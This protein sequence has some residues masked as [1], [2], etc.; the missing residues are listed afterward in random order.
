MKKYKILLYIIAAVMIIT[1]AMIVNRCRKAE[2]N[3]NKTDEK[4]DIS[5][6]SIK[7]DDAEVDDSDYW[8]VGVPNIDIPPLIIWD[9]NGKLTGFE[10]DL[11]KETAKRL[12]LKYK[13]I[14]IYPGMERELLEDEIINVA[15]GNMMDTGKQRLFYDMT[16]PYITI[17]QVI[18]IYE[19]TG[20]ND[21]KDI[22][23]ISVVMST[24]AASLLNDKKIDIDVKKISSYKN[25]TETFG[26]L[27]ESRA[28]AV[29]C[30][31]TMAKYM[32]DLDGNIVIL[33]ESF[34]EIKYSA[35]F[36][37]DQ[38]KIRI[39]VDQVLREI[40]YEGIISDLSYKWFEKDYYFK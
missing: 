23:N 26:Q 37:Y 20:I 22:E 4:I 18:V 12:G 24:P 15:W 17:P 9:E 38:E 19:G 40:S 8:R 32:Q 36:S 27:R 13:I 34:S 28:D 1:V 14:P 31:I 16:E 39:A 5:E 35:A 2:N 30:D 33:D 6:T 25:Y 29:L 7:T 3:N 10:A 11:I 21:K